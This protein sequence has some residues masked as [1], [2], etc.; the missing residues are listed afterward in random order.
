M[1]SDLLCLKGDVMLPPMAIDPI[2]SY[3]VLPV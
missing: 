1:L 3:K 2:E